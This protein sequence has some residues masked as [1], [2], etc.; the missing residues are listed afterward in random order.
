MHIC[1]CLH[2]LYIYVL[3][4]AWLV[5]QPAE[6]VVR[7]AIRPLQAAC[8]LLPLS[9]PTSRDG[10]RISAGSKQSACFLPS[11]PF[12]LPRR[13]LSA[14]KSHTKCHFWIVRITPIRSALLQSLPRAAPTPISNTES[15]C[16]FANLVKS[17]D[18]FIIN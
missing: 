13:I 3:F 9:K 1:A 12:S 15:F 6:P 4:R 8:Q 10:S 11:S 18:T 17:H 14:C 2:C 5:M 16:L 7:A